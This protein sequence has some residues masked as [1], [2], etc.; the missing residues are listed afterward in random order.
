MLIGVGEELAQAVPFDR[1]SSMHVVSSVLS[2]STLQQ[3]A[4]VGIL[5]YFYYVE[6]FLY[7]IRLSFR[8]N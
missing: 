3:A 1:E 4:G 6:A 2:Y 5:I 7:H 8:G